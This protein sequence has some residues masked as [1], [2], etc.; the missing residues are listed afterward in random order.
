MKVRRHIILKIAGLPGLDTITIIFSIDGSTNKAYTH[1]RCQ[2]RRTSY[3][4]PP[5][6]GPAHRPSEVNTSRRPSVSDIFSAGRRN[7]INT[8]SQREFSGEMGFSN[9]SHNRKRLNIKHFILCA[10]RIRTPTE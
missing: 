1:Y 4:R 8:R 2:Q 9:S 10:M 7:A 6:A 3:S 5:R